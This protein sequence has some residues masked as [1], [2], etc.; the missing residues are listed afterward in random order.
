MEMSH[1][2]YACESCGDPQRVNMAQADGRAPV[3]LD[4]RPCDHCGGALSSWPVGI[5]DTM[6][7]LIQEDSVPSSHSRS[8]ASQP[9]Q[10]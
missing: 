10:R 3:S 1:A 2:H 6:E 8:P 4:R 7:R 9:P 5:V